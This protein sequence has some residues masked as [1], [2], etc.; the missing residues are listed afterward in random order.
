MVNQMRKLELEQTHTRFR[1]CR[2]LSILLVVFGLSVALSPTV[3]AADTGNIAAI[4]NTPPKQDL[5]IAT[6]CAVCGMKLHVKN[7]TPGLSYKGKDYYFCAQDERD[8]FAKDPD[9]Y[10]KK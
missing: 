5:G 6:Q 1:F 8:A 4:L 10:L 2:Y 3:R 9:K 7:D